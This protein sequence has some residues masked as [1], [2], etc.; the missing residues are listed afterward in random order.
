M[1]FISFFKGSLSPLHFPLYVL[2]LFG[3][4]YFMGRLPY[5]LSESVRPH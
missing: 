4:N 1:R 2:P 3:S 5:L